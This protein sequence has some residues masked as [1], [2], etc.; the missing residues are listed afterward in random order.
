MKKIISK[1]LVFTI[2]CTTLMSAMVNE[3]SAADPT[4][5]TK[6]SVK[7]VEDANS[8]E[9][10]KVTV[11]MGSQ[12]IPT[13]STNLTS[14]TGN[15]LGSVYVQGYDY[16]DTTLAD[17]GV[18]SM[19]AKGT[20]TPAHILDVTNVSFA[21]LK[22]VKTD[23]KAATIKDETAKTQEAKA[24]A[25]Y[26][27]IMP[28]AYNMA[29]T[30]KFG[31]GAFKDIALEEH[32][33]LT[34]KDAIKFTFYGYTQNVD[35]SKGG[36]VTINSV[37]SFDFN[38]SNIVSERGIPHK[39]DLVY[40]KNKTDVSTAVY[41]LN[42]FVDGVSVSYAA[43]AAGD[44]EESAIT[45]AIYTALN[46]DA[47][48]FSGSLRTG[49]TDWIMFY[50]NTAQMNYTITTTEELN[51]ELLIVPTYKS[52]ANTY[53]TDDYITGVTSVVDSAIKTALET[54]VPGD[55][56]VEIEASA[57]DDVTKVVDTTVDNPTVKL[58]DRITGEKIAYL[59]ATGSMDN[60]YFMV[61]DIYVVPERKESGEITLSAVVSGE[62]ITG[63]ATMNGDK[64]TEGTL[65]VAL[66]SE[67]GNFIKLIPSTEY[68]DSDGTRTMTCDLT[69]A[70]S[71]NTYKVF[72]FDSLASAV[73]LAEMIEG[74]I[75]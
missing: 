66:F 52:V 25:N 37:K 18:S 17:A 38:S 22:G 49:D 53:R 71:G 68:A 48:T 57:Y 43:S 54:T 29:Q 16:G 27:R 41:R 56:I 65:I 14:R 36:E 23:W 33:D 63:I 59:N 20:T 1:F 19:V 30:N 4:A 44:Y 2:A 70:E 6:T 32:K 13:G 60:Y 74:T 51:K 50:D 69:G 15:I 31:S 11:Q 67:K 39:I 58:V 21:G 42:I 64:I 12:Y 35:T 55:K 10:R 73:P 45:T 34:T 61:N 62:K 3:V 40:T 47:A 9:G 28:L 24:T 75:E 5:P 7:V 26:L 72:L 46:L 8:A